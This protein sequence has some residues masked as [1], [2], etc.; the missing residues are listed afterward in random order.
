MIVTILILAVAALLWYFLP[1]LLMAFIGALIAVMLHG[2]AHLVHR[3]L[4]VPRGLAL[5][6]VMILL[7]VTFGLLFWLSGS[8]ISEQMSQFNTMI[9]TSQERLFQLLRRSTWGQFILEHIKGKNMDIAEEMKIF[10]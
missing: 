2:L 9:P 5:P 10:A 1:V 7:A 4:R 8:R 6:V 3:H